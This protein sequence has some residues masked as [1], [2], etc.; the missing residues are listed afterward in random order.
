M[1]KILQDLFNV[2]W[3]YYFFSVQLFLILFS[4]SCM[5][6]CIVKQM[7]CPVENG[8]GQKET[9][10]YLWLTVA[11]NKHEGANVLYVGLFFTL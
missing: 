10:K 8:L 2:F 1:N 6:I 4:I 7:C 11:L 9:Q 3:L 5:F